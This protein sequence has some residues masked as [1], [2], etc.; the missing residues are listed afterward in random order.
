MN[1]FQGCVRCRG[2]AA[3][4]STCEVEAG[5]EVLLALG[6]WVKRRGI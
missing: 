3:R 5:L 2:G 1:E 6:G 4:A